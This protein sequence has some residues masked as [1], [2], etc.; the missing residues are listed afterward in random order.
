MDSK[1]LKGT[2]EKGIMF[3]PGDEFEINC[4]V[5]A[6][7]AALWGVACDQVAVSVKSQT[8]DI[9]M[10]MGCPLLWASNLKLKNIALSIM[11]AEYIAMLSNQ[12]ID[13]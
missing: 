7:F 4:F 11:E 12:G 13:R 3:S 9:I 2:K 5:N 1:I 8:G 10:I 6:D